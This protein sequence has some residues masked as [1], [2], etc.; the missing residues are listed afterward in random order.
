MVIQTSTLRKLGCGFLFAF[1]SNYDSILHQFRDKAGY[2]SKVVIFS[3]PL[4]FDASLGGS[5]SEYCHP[6]WCEKT[7]KAVLPDGGKNLNFQY[8]CLD[9]ILVCDRQMGGRTADTPLNYDV[10]DYLNVFVAAVHHL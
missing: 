8:N 4:A 10:P 7:R 6:V 2:W 5:Q 9:R 1:H 3:Y